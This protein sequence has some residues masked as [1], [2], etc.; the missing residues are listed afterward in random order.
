[1]ISNLRVARLL[2]DISGLFALVSFILWILYNKGGVLNDG[3]T[4][5]HIAAGNKM[6]ANGAILTKDVF[7]H[8]AIDQS[9]TAHEWLAEIIMAVIHK[10]C[11]LPGVAIF[12]FMLASLSFCLLYIVVRKR[13]EEWPSLFFVALALIFSLNHL[14]AR[15]HIFTWFLGGLTLFIISKQDRALFFLP[16]I[17][18]FWANVHAGFILGLL[19]Q[20]IFISGNF[21]DEKCPFTFYDLKNWALKNKIALVSF[22][23]SILAVGINPFGYTL[24]LFPLHVSKGIFALGI[25]EWLSPNLQRHWVFRLYLLSAIFLLSQKSTKTSWAD[26]LSLLLFFNSALV[27]Q[28]HISIAAYYLAPFMAESSY[29]WA[30]SI[31]SNIH[32]PKSQANPLILSKSSG[33]IATVILCIICLMLSSPAFPT[34]RQA[35]KSLIPIPQKKFPVTAIEYLRENRPN[36]KVFNEYSWGGYLIYSFPTQIPVFIDGRAD[37]YGER[38]FGDYQKIRNLNNSAMNLLIDYKIDWVFFPTDSILIRYLLQSKQWKVLY[39]DEDATIIA[40]I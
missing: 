16:L 18:I 33:P 11:G 38:I 14:L 3:D 39:K 36:G 24:Y 28:R 31:F 8:T 1:M 37:M 9:W 34:A 2:P 23:L 13:T 15:P 19:L 4:Y 35:F 7:S 25:N 5:W 32:F 10:F 12:F 6:L 40:R 29:L 22:L 17:I 27:H 30:N 20:A 21:L 26:R